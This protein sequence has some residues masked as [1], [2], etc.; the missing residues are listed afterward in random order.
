MYYIH[1][2]P[3]IC[4]DGYFLFLPKSQSVI[5]IIQ[6]IIRIKY[7]GPTRSASLLDLFLNS[8][9]Q[10]Q[11]LVTSETCHLLKSSFL[12]PNFSL[13]FLFCLLKQMIGEWNPPPPHVIPPQSHMAALRLCCKIKICFQLLLSL[14]DN[15]A[16]ETLSCDLSIF[17]GEKVPCDVIVVICQMMCP[18]IFWGWGL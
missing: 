18:F 7:N 17:L 3:V 11:K 5:N 10:K 16:V 4:M 1:I 2:F 12:T 9:I 8:T 6:Y 13:I 14:F 15:I